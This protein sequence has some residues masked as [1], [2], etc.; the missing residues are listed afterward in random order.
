M[1]LT[2]TDLVEI[3]G[4]EFLMGSEDH[5]PEESPLR[6]VSVDAFC[7][8]AH[9]VTNR[10]FAA[11]VDDTGYR[12]VAERPFE[13]T[14]G[15]RTQQVAPGSMVFTGSRGPVDLRYLANWFT[16]TP[17]AS[18]RHP[19]GPGSDVSDRWDHP[20]AHMAF[21]DA[22]TYVE[23]AGRRL[24]TEAEWE[25]AA[26]GHHSAAPYTWGEEVTPE[27]QRMAKYF[28]GRFPFRNRPSDG[29]LRTAPVGTYPPNDFG[30]VDMAGNVWE[31]TSDWYTETV[32]TPSCCV[33]DNPQGGTERG[34]LDPTQ[35]MF[36]VPR[37]VVKGGSFLCADEYCARYRPAA[38]RGQMVDTGMSHIGFRCASDPA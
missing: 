27:G 23:W 9:P 2:L 28:E 38:R 1:L 8:E 21:E 12:T 15:N 30:L 22:K 24:P 34:S 17:G 36:T 19:E 10:Q 32:E 13:V 33:L 14:D 37:R 20:V 5:Y 7:L 26:R 6:R 29:F 11:M 25:R 4:G 31:W 35:P 18:W 3:P 16:W